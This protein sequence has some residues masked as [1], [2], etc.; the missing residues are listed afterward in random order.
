MNWLLIIEVAVLVSVWGLA[1]LLTARLRSRLGRD[2]AMAAT[3]GGS[4]AHLFAFVSRPVMVL[5][6]TQVVIY[7]VGAVPPW[8]DWLPVF[9]KHLDAWRW[10]WFGVAAIELVHGLVHVVFRWRGEPFPIPDLLLQ[11]TRA[12]LVLGVGFLVLKFKLD[13]DIGPLLAS[14]ALITAVVGFALQGVLGNLL[15]GISLHV[16]R[17]LEP[18]AWVSIDDLEGRIVKTNWR[19]TRI[20]T[21]GGHLYILPNAKV[22]DAKIHH[23]Q[24]PTPLRRNTVVVGASYSDAPDDVIAALLAAAREVEE[25]R[26]SPAPLVH[27]TAYLDF[28]IQYELDFWTMEYHVRRQINGKVNRMIWYKFKRAGI[29]IPFP[30]SD[31]LLNDFMAV[32][33]NQRRLPPLE[34]DLE[35]MVDDLS[36]S[37]LCTELAVDESGE[38]LLSR[39]DLEKVAPFVRRLPFTHGETLCAQ[40]E[41]EETFWIVVR[42]KLSGAVEKDGETIVRFELG[43]GAV[44]GEMSALTGLPRSAT[45]T[46]A[47]TAVLLEFPPPAFRALLALHEALPPRLSDLAAARIAA[48]RQAMEDLARSRQDQAEVPLEKPGIL[49]RLL[50]ML[51]G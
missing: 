10:F 38:P 49:R 12:V 45:I 9:E 39:A 5:V 24:E 32:V 6:V 46:V 7:A 3:V 15:A 43:P 23:M 48:N 35:S 51:R 36:R 17:T 4:L 37:K 1:T 41:E 40:G 25:V 14:T 26:K 18:G 33:Y 42:G 16:V 47:E 21:R 11:I 2:R 30:M 19:E 13:Y 22:A 44:V 34:V 50:R 20:R 8:S 29:E 31:Q 27:I 28:G